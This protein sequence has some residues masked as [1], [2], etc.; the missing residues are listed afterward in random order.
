MSVFAMKLALALVLAALCPG[1]Q[2]AHAQTAPVNY[3]IPGWPLGFGG[4]LTEGQISNTYGNVPGFDSFDARNGGFSYLR[5]NFPNGWFVGSERG[6]LGLGMT[7]IS[8][9]ALGNLGSLQYEGVQLGYNFQNGGGLPVKVF[10]GFDTLKYNTGIGN[11]FA[12]FDNTSNSLSG[13]S[14]RAGIEI[15]PT[16]NLSLSLGVGVTQQPAGDI[17]SLLLP[18]ASPAAISGRR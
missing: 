17:N 4:N 3:W 9:N 5:Y 2:T 15:Q 1:G 11:P 10:A 12:P 7:G 6:G 16:S 18:G 8:Q 14:A 13:Y